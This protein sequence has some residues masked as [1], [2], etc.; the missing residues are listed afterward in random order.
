MAMTVER[1]QDLQKRVLW[2]LYA[3]MVLKVIGDFVPV[4]NFASG[5]LLAVFFAAELFLLSPVGVAI[6]S[7]LVGVL[8]FFLPSLVGFMLALMVESVVLLFAASILCYM[9]SG[10]VLTFVGG[11]L[12][13]VEVVVVTAPMTIAS[14]LAGGVAAL[15]TAIGA[16]AYAAIRGASLTIE[17]CRRR[18]L[19]MFLVNTLVFVVLGWPVLSY[20][21]AINGALACKPAVILNQQHMNEFNIGPKAY[22]GIFESED[23]WAFESQYYDDIIRG[24]N[25]NIAQGKTDLIAGNDEV[26]AVLLN[27]LLYVQDAEVEK[28]IAGG[29]YRAEEGDAMVILGQRV[30]IFGRDRMYICGPEGNYTWKN[31]RYVSEFEALSWEDKCERLY[32]IL[33]RQ[34]TEEDKRFSYEEVGLVARAQRSGL[35]MNYNGKYNEAMFTCPG[36]EGE[37]RFAIQTAP[38]VRQE[39]GFFVP[40][41]S[42]MGRTYVKV[43]MEGILYL[44]GREVRFMSQMDDWKGFYPVTHRSKQGYYRTLNYGWVHG[45]YD[46]RYSAYLDMED[47]LY[48]D[49]RNIGET[50]V[51]QFALTQ[52]T[53]HLLGFA[54]EYLYAIQYKENFLSWLTYI[55]DTWL[56]Y[57][58]EATSSTSGYRA[59]EIWMENWRFQRLRLD[60]EELLK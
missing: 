46:Q 2:I 9:L 1:V 25:N 11:W 22:G 19:M 42:D 39:E 55:P 48:L 43:G 20:T 52:D 35:L 3:A 4:L 12:T 29:A 41:E 57:R 13:S 16:G 28:H 33:E 17:Q 5:I 26:L 7:V 54:G 44:D 36:E 40:D 27:G 51:K 24:N 21:G 59:E 14:G 49:L 10:I 34:N 23:S 58:N 53:N 18:A 8:F 56:A 50:K 37:I 6:M 47:R 38:G 32:E 31:T 45:D 15:G 30:F 60:K